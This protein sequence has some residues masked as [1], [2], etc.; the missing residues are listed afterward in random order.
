MGWNEPM[1]N[2]GAHRV[3]VAELRRRNEALQAEVA[4]REKAERD[5]REQL[6]EAREP[7]GWRS[8][9]WVGQLPAILTAL[10]AV[11][12]LFYT[13]VGLSQSQAATVEQNRIAQSGQITDRFNAAVT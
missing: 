13:A 11:G 5:L 6:K 3:T 10:T 1:V 8:W 7:K 12:A 2:Q 4:T 9:R